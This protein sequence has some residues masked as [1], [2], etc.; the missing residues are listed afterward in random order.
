[1]RL[2]QEALLSRA[3]IGP[4]LVAIFGLLVMIIGFVMALVD[5]V[6]GGSTCTHGAEPVYCPGFQNS[7][8]PG[9]GGFISSTLVP[10]SAP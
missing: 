8:I 3:N 7:T 6:H 9:G 2:R 5:T 10:T 1:M 4:I